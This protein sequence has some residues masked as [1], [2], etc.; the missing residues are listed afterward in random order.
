MPVPSA[1]PPGTFDAHS[2]VPT[3][4]FAPGGRPPGDG[5]DEELR[6]L[7]RSRLILVHALA[8]AL[9]TLIVAV[10]VYWPM[11]SEDSP[12]GPGYWW[13]LALPLAE[14]LVGAVV[15]WRSPGMSQQSLRLWE[16]AHFG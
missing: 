12:R 15:L 13:G 16:V 3:T 9:G 8:L 10:S 7:L 2:G 11:Q 5:F 6:R 14:C 4:S 1:G